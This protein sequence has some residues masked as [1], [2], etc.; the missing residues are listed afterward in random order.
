MIKKVA[1]VSN[2]KKTGA[3]E[4]RD[5]IKKWLASRDLEIMEAESETVTTEI[6]S[7]ELVICLGGDGTILSV[8]RK[9]KGATVPILGVN[10]GR[11]GFLTEVKVDEVF[12]ELNNVLL[13][14][15]QTEE[16]LMLACDIANDSGKIKRR[17][18]A[19]NDVTISREGLTRLLFVEVMISGEPF[20]SFRGDGLIVS[21]PTGSTAYSLSAGGPIV[22]PKLEVLIITPICPHAS[23]LRPFV[24]G[25]DEK[26]AVRI[27]TTYKGEKALLTADGQENFEIDDSFNVKIT[28]AEGAAR[29]IKSSKRSYISALR[30]NFKFPHA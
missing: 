26:I 23:S 11:L 9:I 12:E 24:V 20:T 27:Q 30:E 4:L 17:F 13:G 18:S 14:Q 15:F 21:T 1:V 29:L 2:I 8:A 10:L 5:K 16:R 22:H 25:A 3:V 7:A 19:L 28:R 6:Q